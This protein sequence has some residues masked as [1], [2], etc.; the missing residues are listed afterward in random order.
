[1]SNE[2]GR[3]TMLNE[4][5]L[6][7]IKDGILNGDTYLKISQD[8][9]VPYDTFEGWIKRNYDNFADTLLTYKHERLLRKAERNIEDVMDMSTQN[10][11]MT[12][13]GEQY[14]FHDPKLEAIKA[15][16][17]KFALETLGRNNYHRKTENDNVNKNITWQFVRGDANTDSRPIPQSTSAVA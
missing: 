14:E 6:V 16:V 7:K 2:V 4:M 5:L 12:M 11:G 15:D 17:S 1:M 13:K 8:I 3:P 10:T 9:G